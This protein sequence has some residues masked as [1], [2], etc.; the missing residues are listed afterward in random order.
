MKLLAVTVLTSFDQQDLRELGYDCTLADL[1]HQRFRLAMQT[2][3]VRSPLEA[4]AIR[5][6]AGPASILVTP[7]VGSRGADYL[8]I[9]SQ[10]TR[11]ANPPAALAA[12]HAE[13]QGETQ[14]KKHGTRDFS[15]VNAGP[16]ERG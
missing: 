16:G 1:V 8:V 11:S 15:R 6:E 5:A 13:L 2:G 7:G 4:C 3:V 14:T 12:I 9:G 10:V